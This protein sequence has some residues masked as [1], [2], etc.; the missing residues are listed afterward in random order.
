MRNDEGAGDGCTGVAGHAQHLEQD[1][2]TPASLGGSQLVDVGDRN[3]QGPADHQAF[4]QPQNQHERIVGR[5]GGAERQHA[6][7]RHRSDKHRLTPDPLGQGAQDHGADELAAIAGRDH[8]AHRHGLQMPFGRH[9]GQHIGDRDAVPGVE[10]HDDAEQ[11]RR[12]KSDAEGSQIIQHSA[13]AG[14]E[15]RRGDRRGNGGCAHRAAPMS[16]ATVDGLRDLGFTRFLPL[17]LWQATQDRPSPRD[18]DHRGE[19]G[20]G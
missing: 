12:P 11:D 4:G 17:F 20:F 16:T 6:H 8:E 2:I 19:N 15:P 7:D 10:H 3:R 1:E 13:D 9:G 5:E 14:F 18:I